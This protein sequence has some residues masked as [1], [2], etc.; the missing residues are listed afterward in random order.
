MRLNGGCVD[1]DFLQIRVC[2]KLMEYL[3]DHPGSDHSL[4][5]LYT[6]CRSYRSGTSCHAASVRATH[7]RPSGNSRAP[8]WYRFI[9]PIFRVRKCCLIRYYSSFVITYRRIILPNLITSW[10]IF[11]V[12]CLFLL[13]YFG[14]SHFSSLPLVMTLVTASKSPN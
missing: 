1:H 13:A 10:V 9:S 12:N 6:I 3:F 8:R 2:S 5:R 11:D 4:N 7:R 14:F